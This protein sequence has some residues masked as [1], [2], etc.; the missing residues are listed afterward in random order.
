M[1]SLISGGIETFLGELKV[2]SRLGPHM[3]AVTWLG[4]AFSL[5][6]S[7]FSVLAPAASVFNGTVRGGVLVYYLCYRACDLELAHP[8]ILGEFYSFF[9][10]ESHRQS[11]I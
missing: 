4:S 6:A 10:S 7:L 1:Y 2:H 9:G 11:T 3:L 8:V 5:G